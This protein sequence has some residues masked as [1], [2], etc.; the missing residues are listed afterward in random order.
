MAR[1]AKQYLANSHENDG[2]LLDKYEML[3]FEAGE[4]FK[5]SE[6]D[7]CIS[8]IKNIQDSGLANTNDRK[9]CCLLFLGRC[10][11]RQ[12][13]QLQLATTNLKV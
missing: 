1:R 4:R 12:E 7:Q 9:A 6:W 2:V 8:L 13:N 3:L 11:R 5:I 10:Y